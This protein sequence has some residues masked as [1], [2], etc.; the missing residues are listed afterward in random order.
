MATL[1]GW[2]AIAAYTAA[3]VDLFTR[4]ATV[5]MDGPDVGFCFSMLMPG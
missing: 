4:T 3:H 5:N 2:Y 1:A